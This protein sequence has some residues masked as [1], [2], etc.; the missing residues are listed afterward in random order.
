MANDSL[1]QEP[2]DDPFKVANFITEACIANGIT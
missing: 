1:K 2:K